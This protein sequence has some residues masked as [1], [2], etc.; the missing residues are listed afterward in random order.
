MIRRT[1][2]QK[3][4]LHDL[5]ILARFVDSGQDALIGGKE[6]GRQVVQCPFPSP[7]RSKLAEVI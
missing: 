1:D 4:S 3:S 2:Q 6:R 7:I 5:L